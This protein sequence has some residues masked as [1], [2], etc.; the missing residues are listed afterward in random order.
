MKFL[1]LFAGIGGFRLG[2]ESLGHECVGFCEIDKY[3]VAS[4][5]SMYLITDEQREYLMTL[6]KKDRLNEILKEEYRNGEWY[7]N[8]IRSVRWGDIPKADCWCFGFPCQDI[9]LSGN[10]LGFAGHR[11]SLFFTVT[12]LINHTEEKDRPKYL[13][14]ENVKNLLSIN[15]GFDFAKLLIEL[16]KIGY[17]AEWAV[18]NSKGFGVPQNRERC[19][20][21]GHSRIGDGGSQVFPLQSTNGEHNIQGIGKVDLLGHRNNYRRTTQIFNPNGITEVLDT[22]TGGGEESTFQLKI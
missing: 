14:I 1:D 7:A 13:F 16:D 8:D 17:D 10:K 11:S 5:T 19:F 2:M 21:I 9:S 20:I 3:A 18:L 12:D 4:Y 6:P 15:R 22:Q